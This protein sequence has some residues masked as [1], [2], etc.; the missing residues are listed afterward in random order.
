MS[1]AATA[2]DTDLPPASSRSPFQA[3]LAASACSRCAPICV[4]LGSR[5]L[6]ACDTAPP[7][8]TSERE[9]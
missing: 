3:T 8:I 7:D 5:R 4:S 9:A 6:Q 2:A 1:A